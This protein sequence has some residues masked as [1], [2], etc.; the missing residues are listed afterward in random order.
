MLAIKI[1]NTASRWKAFQFLITVKVVILSFLTITLQSLDFSSKNALAVFAG[2]N[3]ISS[4]MIKASKK[5]HLKNPVRLVRYGLA[6]S[7]GFLFT[8]SLTYSLYPYTSLI[9]LT[10]GITTITVVCDLFGSESLISI[11]N[12]AN[13][14][15]IDRVLLMTVSGFVTSVIV[16]I[17]FPVFG[18]IADLSPILFFLSMSLLILYALTFKAFSS[19]NCVSKKTSIDKFKP[20]RG[21]FGMAVLFNSV[22]LIGR[23][24]ILPLFVAD[25]ALEY[26]FTGNVIRLIGIILG[27]IAL[28]ALISR[29]SIKKIELPAQTSMN[30]GFIVGVISWVGITI[31]SMAQ[32]TIFNLSISILLIIIFEITVKFWN[33]GYFGLLREFA[34]NDEIGT[35]PEI[36]YS[37]YFSSHLGTNKVCSGISFL[38]MYLLYDFIE[39]GNLVVISGFI[40]ILYMLIYNSALRKSAVESN[41]HKT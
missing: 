27:V 40:A 9:L 26:G 3:L 18:T 15:A 6:A 17:A 8:F 16:A 41:K 31:N 32:N 35:N 1:L 23:Y 29:V 14:H 34:D 38:L 10:V 12:A 33:A 39:P 2:I 22:T 30:F 11:H 19:D 21:L 25:V 4:I 24:F 37:S 7:G 20:P 28:I 13:K 36:R 5:Q